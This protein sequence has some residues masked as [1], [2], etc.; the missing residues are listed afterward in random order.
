MMKDHLQRQTYTHLEEFRFE[1][2]EEADD[3]PWGSTMFDDMHLDEVR[4][5][6]PTVSTAKKYSTKTNK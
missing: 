6:R 2:Q 3:N 1:M 5:K 4:K